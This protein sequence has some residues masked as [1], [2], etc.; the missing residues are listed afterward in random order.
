MRVAVS[1]ASGLIGTALV[2]ELAGGGADVL[3]LVRHQPRSSAE[4]RWQPEAP[5]GGLDPAALRGVDAVIHLSGAPVAPRRWTQARK[6]VLRSSRIESTRNLASAMAAA[7][8]GPTVLAC[9]SAIGY[10]GDTGNRAVDESAPPGDGFLAGLVRDWEAAAEPARAAGIRVVNFRSGLV[11]AP[12]G[13]ILARLLLPFRFGL[14]ATF[15]SGRQYMSWISLADEVSA[16]RFLLEAGDAS[17]AFNL[18]APEP[19]TNAE[20]TAALARAAGRPAL[21]K[22]PAVALRA[23]LG[24]V[25]SELLGSALRAIA[26]A[27][28][29]SGSSTSSA[30]STLATN[31]GVLTSRTTSN[32]AS[33]SSNDASTTRQMIRSWRRRQAVHPVTANAPSSA[34]SNPTHAPRQLP[35]W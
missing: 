30:D 24:E 32:Q 8:P 13:G 15:G 18:T 23:A 10:Y 12:G 29:A 5:S 26:I 2:R 19:V 11:L 31:P 22:L 14:G 4:L 34:T 7:E 20:F 35:V 28:S 3:R 1:A 21:L 9:A 25:A 33:H 27:S 17:G 16:I 6:A